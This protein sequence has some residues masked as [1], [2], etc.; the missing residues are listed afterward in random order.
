MGLGRRDRAQGS[1]RMLGFPYLEHDTTR[2]SVHISTTS[3][4]SEDRQSGNRKTRVQSRERT[5]TKE[6]EVYAT[7][8]PTLHYLLIPSHHIPYPLSTF[9]KCIDYGVVG[10]QC[11]SS[12]PG[13]VF[14]TSLAR[15]VDMYLEAQEIDNAYSTRQR[16]AL[17]LV[18]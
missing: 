8:H 13:P 17:V 9:F 2:C 14:P 6:H 16:S 15:A 1:D 7:I 18:F 10:C 5:W 12:H 3:R 4:R 11:H